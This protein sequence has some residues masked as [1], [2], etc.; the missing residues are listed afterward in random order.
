MN[1]TA[2]LATCISFALGLYSRVNAGDN[3]TSIIESF[4][5][6]MQEFFHS[7]LRLCEEIVLGNDPI[8]KMESFMLCVFANMPSGINPITVR[9]AVRA[10][11]DR[12]S[13]TSE[14]N[15]TSGPDVEPDEG[16]EVGPVENPVETFH[17]GFQQYYFLPNVTQALP[18]LDPCIGT[19]QVDLQRTLESFLSCYF[20]LMPCILVEEVVVRARVQ[21]SFLQYLAQRDKDSKSHGRR[22]VHFVETS[23]PETS[24][25]NFYSE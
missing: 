9:L 10:S 6:S 15:G 5:R 3:I 13:F 20:N 18:A 8:S 1:D 22:R 14:E 2:E 19:S 21:D 7:T 17:L 11:F 23:W 25:C 12:Y 4:P 16:P 24:T